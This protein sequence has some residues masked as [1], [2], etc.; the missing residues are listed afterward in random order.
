MAHDI[1]SFGLGSFIEGYNGK[2][3][4]VTKSGTPYCGDKF[5]EYCIDVQEWNWAARSAFCG[6]ILDLLPRMCINVGFTIEARE[7]HETPECIFGCCMLNFMAPR[8]L[9][10]LSDQASHLRTEEVV[11]GGAAAAGVSSAVNT[12]RPDAGA[13]AAGAE[14]SGV[15]VGSVDAAAFA[16]RQT[17][18]KK[19][20]LSNAAAGAP[21]PLSTAAAA[22]LPH[23]SPPQKPLQH[24]SPEAL[25]SLMSISESLAHLNHERFTQFA[26]ATPFPAVLL[27]QGDAYKPLDA[28]TFTPEQAQYCQRH[29]LIL[30]GLYGLLRPYDD[31]QPYRLEM[32]TRLTTPHG[33]SLYSFWGSK[34][35]QHLNQQLATH[36]HRYVINLASNEYSQAIDTQTLAHPLI[37]VQFKEPYGD[38]YRVIG[39]QAK[40][41]RGLMA[42][43]IMTEQIDTPKSIQGFQAY[44]YRFQPQLSSSSMYLFHRT[45][46]Q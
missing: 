23:P 15:V 43:Y 36:T 9:L 2:P 39:I 8:Q 33:N 34:L 44:G 24:L 19:N 3:V 16:M 4:L 27:F 42:R 7:K 28:A 10:P 32:K 41:A 46:D 1:Q 17:A 21:L 22:A 40:K 6:T 11:R 18:L 26:S 37:T 29:L 13:R 25:R 45:H 20:P 30:S 31:I 12:G 5:L 38:D 35:A 14:G